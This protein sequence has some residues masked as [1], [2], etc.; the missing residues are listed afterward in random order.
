MLSL[1][2]GQLECATVLIVKYKADTNKANA[3]NYPLH[4]AIKYSYGQLIDILLQHGADVNRCDKETNKS[5]LYLAVEV[6]D[7][8]MAS[9]LLEAKADFALKDNVLGE[10][11]L[12]LSMRICKKTREIMLTGLLLDRTKQNAQLIDIQ[13]KAGNTA[14][15]IAVQRCSPPQSPTSLVALILG[16]NPNPLIKNK[17]GE[18]P[19][20]LVPKTPEKQKLAEMLNEYM[21]KWTKENPTKISSDQDDDTEIG[22]LRRVCERLIIG[23]STT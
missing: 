20:D 3:G 12:H 13:D 19:S 7:Y 6:Q 14:L 1:E 2:T 23:S 11:P 16:F 15:H 22:T 18:I 21:I 17:K 10:T 9:K 8:D 4:L 5:P